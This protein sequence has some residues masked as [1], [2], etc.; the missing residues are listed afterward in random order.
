LNLLVE[1]SGDENLDSM[2]N[3]M[4]SGAMRS[5]KEENV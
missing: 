3:L 2:Q 1:V 4:R 5:N